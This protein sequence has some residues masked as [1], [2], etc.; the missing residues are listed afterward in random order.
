MSPSDGNTTILDPRESVLVGGLGLECCHP[1][2]S[3]IASVLCEPKAVLGAL[4]K[5]ISLSP[6]K[7][8]CL[9]ARMLSLQEVTELPGESP[10][11]EEADR[12]T[13]RSVQTPE[14][15]GPGD[16]VIFYYSVCFQ[17]AFQYGD[18][19]L[20]LWGDAVRQNRGCALDMVT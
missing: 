15:Y 18:I 8:S 10:L 6:L 11:L 9:M 16:Q 14:L 1:N 13:P 4:P 17:T 12:S 5:L 2:D 19:T 3:L 20:I 7:R